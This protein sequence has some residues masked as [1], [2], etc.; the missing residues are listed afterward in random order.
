MTKKKIALLIVLVLLGIQAIRPSRAIPKVNP[1]DDFV[2]I[3]PGDKATKELFKAACYDCHSYETKYPWYAEIA[4]VSWIVQ[5]HV[6]HGRSH[7]NFSEWGTRGKAKRAHALEEM[8]E[9]TLEGEMPL[10]AY[11][12]MHPEARLDSAQERKLVA[13]WKGLRP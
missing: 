12:N 1:A 9:E 3:Y 2:K 11:V 10:K 6:R 4:P 5:D 13:W 7:L 8:V